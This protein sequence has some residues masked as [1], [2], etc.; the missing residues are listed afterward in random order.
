MRL[1]FIIVFEHVVFFLSLIVWLVPD[2]PAILATKI[3]RGRYLAKLALADNRVALLS[4][5]RCPWSP[6][7]RG[8]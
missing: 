4:Q 6:G 7:R 1:G 2:V 8:E 3:K 5:G